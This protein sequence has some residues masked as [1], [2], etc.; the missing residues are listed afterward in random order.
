MHVD[1]GNRVKNLIREKNV[2]LKEVAD[3]S[4][5]SQATLSDLCNNKKSPKLNT[6]ENI[7]T[8][9][10]LSLGEFFTGSKLALTDDIRAA[11]QCPAAVQALLETYKRINEVSPMQTEINKYRKKQ[12]VALIELA[13]FT[14]MT[15]EEIQKADNGEI[16][17][18][19]DQMKEMYE[20]INQ[21]VFKRAKRKIELKSYET[22]L[23]D[24]KNRGLI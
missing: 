3:R 17:L 6:L 15:M 14:H 8:A 20:A 7:C 23:N 12:N 4:G 13:Q 24:L 21:V 5:L 16:K 1:I 11:L 18:N 9:L 22:W 10:D 2:R 19:M